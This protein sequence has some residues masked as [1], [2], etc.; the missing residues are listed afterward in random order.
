MLE[1]L[2]STF[3]FRNVRQP[4]RMHSSISNLEDGESDAGSVA[5]DVSSKRTST[6]TAGLMKPPVN[7]YV[8]QSPK[9]KPPAKSDDDFS[10]LEAILKKE[11]SS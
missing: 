4:K 9:A 6:K 5:N 2:D 11:L 10:D 8:P 1:K 3:N 7:N